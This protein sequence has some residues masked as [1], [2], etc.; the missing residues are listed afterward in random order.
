MN[1]E[2]KSDGSTPSRHVTSGE[3][4]IVR[5]GGFAIL[6]FF[7]Y[8]VSDLSSLVL[9]QFGNAQFAAGN[10]RLGRGSYTLALELKP[11]L[12][13]VMSQCDSDIV[14]QQYESTIEHC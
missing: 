8:I 7:V 11:G 5:I 4:L 3:Q 2:S 10:M 12:K 14:E 9:I 1:Q 6:V 13:K